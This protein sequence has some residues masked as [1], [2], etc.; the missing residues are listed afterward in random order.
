MRKDKRQEL[1]DHSLENLQAIVDGAQQMAASLYEENVKKD[2]QIL[3]L[4]ELVTSLYEQQMDVTSTANKTAD[5]AK[6]Q[7]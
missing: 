3:S 1:R 2:E 4:Q 7:K 5:Q 6:E